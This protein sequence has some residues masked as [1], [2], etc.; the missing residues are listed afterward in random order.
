VLQCSTKTS[1]EVHVTNLR[2]VEASFSSVQV[3][4]SELATSDMSAAK[5]DTEN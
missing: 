5:N 2:V 3:L 1:E 4:Q